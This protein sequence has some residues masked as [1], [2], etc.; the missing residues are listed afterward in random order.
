ML[1]IRS[2]PLFAFGRCRVGACSKS[3]LHLEPP[4]LGLQKGGFPN[5][6]HPAKQIYQK[7]T[8]HMVGACLFRRL[9]LFFSGLGKPKSHTEAHPGRPPRWRPRRGAKLHPTT[10][11]GRVGWSERWMVLMDH[12]GV[13]QNSRARVT[14]V[15]VSGSIYQGA[16]LIRLLEPLPFG[17]AA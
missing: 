6:S 11:T 2:T 1:A 7:K 10:P 3:N 5:P 17:S 14:R 15:L 4:H 13:A 8:T 12:L 9:P 16:I